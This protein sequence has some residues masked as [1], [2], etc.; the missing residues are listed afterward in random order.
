MGK[1]YVGHGF[2]FLH[3]K[4]SK[5]GL[6]LMEPKQRIVILTEVLRNRLPSSRL[7]DN[8]KRWTQKFWHPRPNEAVNK[9]DLSTGENGELRADV[10]GSRAQLPST[11]ALN[12]FGGSVARNRTSAECLG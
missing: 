5:I 12:A 3:F 1:W 2:D 10:A 7:L 11:G 4:Y 9:W 6:P 8:P